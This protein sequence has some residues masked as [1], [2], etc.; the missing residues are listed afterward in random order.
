MAEHLGLYLALGLLA[1]ILLAL[2]LLLMK[3][4]GAA[5]PAAGGS[6]FLRAI[7]RW[8]RDP[9]WLAGIAIQTLGYA[10]YL[11]ALSGAPV[12]ML[13][14]MMQGGI[15]V[16][17]ILAAVVLRER[18]SMREWLGIIGVIVA[19]LLLVASLDGQSRDSN[20]NFPALHA[21]TIVSIVVACLPSLIGR[22]R[23][24]GLATA[25]AAGIAFGLGSL[26]AKIVTLLLVGAKLPI[27]ITLLT[28]PWLY[29]TIAANIAGLVLL[30]NSFH[31]A[32]GIIAMPLSSAC[33]NVVPIIGGVVALGEILPAAGSFA[34]M[35]VTAYVL[36]IISSGLLATG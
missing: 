32:R 13:A 24:E 3:S 1:S 7:A 23:N 30:Q 14:V 29:L 16:F 18:A 36:T 2:G 10:L 4:R 33:S 8:L 27:A 12:S 35:R 26:Y 28:N 9:V 15:A 21:V 5:L 31:L 20:P 19:M 22:L 11:V 6:N 25:F 17:V 34:T